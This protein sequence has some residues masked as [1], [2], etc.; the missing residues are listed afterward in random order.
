MNPDARGSGRPGWT[1]VG[2][3]GALTPFPFFFTDQHLPLHGRPTVR[4]PDDLESAPVRADDLLRHRRER[5]VHA[6][7]VLEFAFED[8]DADR[9]ALVWPGEQGPWRGWPCV[10]PTRQDGARDAG[11]AAVFRERAARR[12]YAHVGVVGQFGNPPASPLRE[13]ALLQNLKAPGD[14]PPE[15]H[16]VPRARLLLAEDLPVLLLQLGHAQRE[17]RFP[18]NGVTKRRALS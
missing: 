1:A 6:P 10:A 5:P 13:V 18:E 12:P 15:E 14:S 2:T 3:G 8:G 7:L 17:G 9:S 16:R 11:R 4:E